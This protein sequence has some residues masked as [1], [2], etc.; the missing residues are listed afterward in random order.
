MPPAQEGYVLRRTAMTLALVMVAA[1]CGGNDEATE[2]TTAPVTTEAVTTTAMPPE[3]TTTTAAPP[4]TTEAAPADPY[5]AWIDVFAVQ[6]N[7]AT[8]TYNAA[9]DDPDYAVSPVVVY[10]DEP[11]GH[12][13]FFAGE[14]P[15]ADGEPYPADD[16]LAEVIFNETC[17]QP[18]VDQIGVDYDEI[19]L[20]VWG[21]WPPEAAWEAGE[22]TI[23]CSVANADNAIDGTPLI[24]TVNPAVLRLPGHLMAAV[25]EFDERDLWLYVFGPEGERLDLINLTADG[26][27]LAE[28]LTPP[29]WSP[30]LTKIVYAAEHP[31]GTGDLFLL[32]LVSGTRTQ[33]TDDASND[34]GPAFSPDGTKILFSSDRN[35]DDLDLFIMDVDGSNVVQLTDNPDRE[36]SGDWSPDGTQIV[37]RQRIDGQSDIWIM[38]ADGSDQRYFRG[39]DGGEYDPDWSPDGTQILYITDDTANGAFD[40]MVAPVD[41]D[42]ATNL[43]DH[44]ASD[45]YPEWSPDGE[46][47][48]FNSDRHG[49]QGLF[50]MRADGSGQSAFVWSWPVGYAQLALPA[51]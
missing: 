17:A 8:F 38:N 27:E 16:T 41:G 1:A 7:C 12:Q 48:I 2:T 3:T 11:H 13:V 10:C 42:G 15:A 43:T 49:Y 47:V 6:G 20:D 9:G 37:Y 32:D 39:G 30:D 45:E 21:F 40:I 24:G 33:L 34:G 51:P 44:P 50:I 31:D 4:E 36:S 25:G 35:S 29:S 28:R 19:T 26:S 23:A 18:L 22:R 5:S 46:Y 14:Y